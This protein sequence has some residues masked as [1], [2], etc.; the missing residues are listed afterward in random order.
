MCCPH[1]NG[2]YGFTPGTSPGKNAVIMLMGHAKDTGN[3]EMKD[4]EAI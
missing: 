1:H 3:Q 4:N 2:H